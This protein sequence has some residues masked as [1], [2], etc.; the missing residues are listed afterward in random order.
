MGETVT[1]VMNIAICTKGYR[2]L[3]LCPYMAF[4]SDRTAL[5]HFFTV[6]TAYTYRAVKELVST[7][8]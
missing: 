3:A 7:S 6:F 8:E 1:A 5:Q 2:V 4:Y